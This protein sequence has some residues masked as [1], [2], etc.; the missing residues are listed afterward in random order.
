ME[1]NTKIALE[2]S[3]TVLDMTSYIKAV[4]Y[5]ENPLNTDPFWQSLSDE[6]V[7]SVDRGVYEWLDY[8]NDGSKKRYGKAT[9][10]K[11]LKSCMG[12]IYREVSVQD[13]DFDQFPE[14]VAEA[15]SMTKRTLSK[16]RWI[17]MAT[18]QFKRACMSVV[19]ER[20]KQIREYYVTMGESL[21]L[22]NHYVVRFYER[23]A[24]G[25]VDDE[26]E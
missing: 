22:Y 18:D 2:S 9:F 4:D 6:R 16:Y 24:E 7:V 15:Q 13:V 23:E 14:F 20:G 12:L 8:G 17:V 10:Y 1:N 21:F 11:H 19:S 26:K 25:L 5:K 3:K